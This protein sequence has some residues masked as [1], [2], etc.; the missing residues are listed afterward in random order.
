[1]KQRIIT[2]GIGGI[3][4]I[5]ILVI[6]GGWFATLISLLAIIGYIELLRMAKIKASSIPALLGQ[7]MLILILTSA[8]VEPSS[9]FLEQ[10]HLQVLVGV[11]LLLLT[12]IV[13]SK[14]AF[15][16]EQAGLLFIG[17]IYI[18]YGFY[19]LIETRLE[20]GLQW[21]FFIILIIWCTDSGAYFTGRRFGKRKLWPTISP[22]KTIEG[23]IGGIIFALIVGLIFYWTTK[24]ES[25]SVLLLVSI[26][27]SII[28][29]LGDLA[30]S[31]IKRHFHVK[32]SGRLLPG[33]GGVLDR[34][35]SILFAFPMVYILQIFM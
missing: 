24:L 34:F 21:T 8:F 2:G 25:L 33:H 19:F 4:F 23:A 32:D 35:D 18:G 15:T 16:I 3:G 5:A 7:I 17:L 29:Q 9:T 14:N 11:S 31:A 26:I 6:G 10:Y 30:E 20:L 28:G 27:I 22:N 13:F 12:S 1:M